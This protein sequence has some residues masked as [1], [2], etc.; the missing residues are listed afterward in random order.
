MEENKN[1]ENNE[2]KKNKNRK[3]Y[4]REY[5]LKKRHQMI[6][7]KFHKDNNSKKNE[8]QFSIKHGVFVVSFK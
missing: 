4:M 1:S 2:L 3:K 5:Y 7:G 8:N 6:N